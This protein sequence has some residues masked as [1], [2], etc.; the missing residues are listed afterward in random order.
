MKKPE[1]ASGQDE[2]QRTRQSK[3]ENGEDEVQKKMKKV[4]SRQEAREKALK[5]GA[6]NDAEDKDKKTSKTGRDAT[7]AASSSQAPEAGPS[8]HREVIQD[9]LM[10]PNVAMVPMTI[11][12]RD[13]ENACGEDEPPEK[14]HKISSICVGLGAADKLGEL[15]AK[16]Y[17]ED[18][19]RMAEEYGAAIKSGSCFVHIRQKQSSNKDLKMLSRLTKGGRFCKVNLSG[20]RM[21]SVITNSKYLAGMLE[22]AGCDSREKIEEELE[23][24]TKGRN[25]E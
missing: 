4:K 2:D 6:E 3:R 1:Q 24:E 12:K 23:K 13:L 14:S 11:D 17:D 10:D 20:E 5:R 16:E 22:R 8:D 25:W 15:S 21:E 7:E 9:N 19:A 18:L